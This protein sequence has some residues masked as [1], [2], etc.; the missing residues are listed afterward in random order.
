MKKTYITPKIDVVAIQTRSIIC[1]SVG[2]GG[3]AKDSGIKSADSPEF[4]WD[5]F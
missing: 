5:D 2:M 3:S 4:E 1:T